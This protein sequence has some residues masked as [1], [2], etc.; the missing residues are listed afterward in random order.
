MSLGRAFAYAGCP[1]VIMSH[2]SVDDKSTASIMENF[3][4]ALANDESRD[5]AMQQA[6]IKFLEE[7]SELKQHPV[8]W[9][10]FV[11]MGDSA[12]ITK[13]SNNWAYWMIFLTVAT[14][15]VISFAL[16]PRK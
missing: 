15:I 5:V 7:A 2:W 13:Q 12:P 8:Y 6:K 4:T 9:A 11:L 1:S 14:G 16:R 10:G 3:Y